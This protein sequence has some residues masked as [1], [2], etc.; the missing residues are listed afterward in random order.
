MPGQRSKGNPDPSRA[1]GPSSAV[2]PLPVA[3]IEPTF[4][5]PLVSP[6]GAAPLPAPGLIAAGAAAVALSMITAGAEKKQSAAFATRA[7]PWP[8]NYFAN[9][10]HAYSQGGTGQRPRLRGRLEPV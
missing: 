10:R 8:E 5:T 9:N 7:N 2:L 1:L 3:M 6:I 4:R